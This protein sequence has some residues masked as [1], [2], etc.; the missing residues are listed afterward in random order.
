MKHHQLSIRKIDTAQPGKH[1]DGLGLRLVVSKNFSKR[2]VYRYSLNKK[3]REM[4]LGAYPA[5][6]LKEARALR[7]QYEQ[8]LSQGIDPI[9]HRNTKKQTTPTFLSCAARYIKAHRRGWKNKKHQSQWVNTIKTYVKP[10]MGN[11]PIDT[12]T[13]VVLQLKPL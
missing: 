3:R 4:G 10:V 7:K 5:I 8:Q 1:E 13:L 12:I 6:G 2:W 11:T 9:Q